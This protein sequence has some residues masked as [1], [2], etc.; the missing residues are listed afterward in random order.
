[1]SPIVNTW[2]SVVARELALLRFSRD[3]RGGTRLDRE[4]SNTRE[5][6]QTLTKNNCPRP[7]STAASRNNNR[8]SGPTF[9]SLSKSFN[10]S[11]LPLD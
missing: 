1:M 11:R 7:P 10:L 5:A 9:L 2:P 8:F 3:E 6:G 4:M